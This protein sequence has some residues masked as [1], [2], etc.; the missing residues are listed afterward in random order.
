VSL[1]TGLDAC[2]DAIDEIQA[3]EVGK[4]HSGHANANYAD[5]SFP[6]SFL[7]AER[8]IF[9]GFLLVAR[10]IRASTNVS[11]NV[12]NDDARRSM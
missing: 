4:W 3:Q 6:F 11:K 8:R 10:S 12:S 7:F 1:R 5:L 2:R 9:H